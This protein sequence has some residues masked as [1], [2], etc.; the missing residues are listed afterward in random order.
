MEYFAALASGEPGAPRAR[1][2]YA[3]ELFKAER[4]DEAAREFQAYLEL[5]EDE[6]N[7]WGKLGECLARL[8]RV[9]Q[10]ADAYLVGI[11]QAA[12]FGHNGMAD[13]FRDAVER[14]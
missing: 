5:A 14:L 11:D 6:G 8:G 4:W 7:A 10:A 1:F 9:D 3:H 13:D 12:K 2:G